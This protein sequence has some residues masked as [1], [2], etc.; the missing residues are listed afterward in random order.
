MF[1]EVT[2]AALD[3]Q[4]Y[5][6]RLKAK[7]TNAGAIVTFTGLVRDY[8][9]EGGIDGISL[10][11]YPG[12]TEA[13]MMKLLEQAKMQ[14]D[15]RSAGIVHRYGFVGNH[16][17]IVWVGCAAS[18]RKAAFE[19]AEFVMDMLKKSVPLWKKEH[20]DGDATWVA[21]KA[22]DEEAAMKWLNQK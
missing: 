12:M 20:Q 21:A 4:A 15:L 18:H 22:S 7:A 3:E 10:E 13:A 8:N 11:H 5:N 6:T 1:A 14:F 16:E 17:P 19:A 2:D 9:N